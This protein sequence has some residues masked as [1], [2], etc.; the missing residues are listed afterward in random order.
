MKAMAAKTERR[1]EAILRNLVDQIVS[2]AI[3]VGAHIPFEIEIMARHAVSRTVARDALQRLAGFGMVDVRRRSGAVVVPSERWNMFEPLVL[4]ATIKGKPNAA[5]L[6][7]LFEA[8]LIL[9]PEAAALAA[10]RIDA[11]ALDDMAA[12]LA[13]MRG[14]PMQDAFLEA[15]M[16]FHTTILAATGNWVLRRFAGVIRAALLASISLTRARSPS[17]MLDRSIDMHAQVLSAI[18]SGDSVRS[19]LTMTW[20]LTEARV[21]LETALHED[22]S[23]AGHNP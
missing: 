8:R 6:G 2:G 15:D 3:P 19:R 11:I 18:R 16:R 20:F 1:H 10:T 17:P 13:V 12:A 14:G 4:D 5:F 22:P 23:Q 21:N 7:G 9:E